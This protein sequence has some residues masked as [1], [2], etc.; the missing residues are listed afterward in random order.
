M[1]APAPLA[2]GGYGT[3]EVTAMLG[4]GAARLRALVRSGVVGT[5]RGALGEPRFGF[6]DLVLL[7][8]AQGL[9]AA[10]IPIRRVER[11]LAR[12]AAQLPEPALLS[13]LRITAERGEIV[14]RDGERAWNP[15]SGQVVLDFEVAEVAELAAVAAGAAVVTAARPVS[16]AALSFAAAVERRR[17]AAAAEAT[18]TA[19]APGSGATDTDVDTD[20]DT[21]TERDIDADGWYAVGCELEAH[22]P[23]AAVDAYARALAL[24]PAHADTHL[25]LGRLWHQTGNAVRAEHHYRLALAARP[26]D[27][28]AAF[29]LGV[30]LDDQGRDTDAAAAYEAAIAVDAAHAD[31]HYNL[32]LARERLGDRQAALRHL[33]DYRRLLRG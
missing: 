28:T 17:A 15:D 18:P 29:D 16:G 31:A 19:E 14:V 24:A 32:A 25:N 10:R 22:D 6:R 2:T 20:T 4:I 13:R 23:V 1:T 21:D 26:G 9:F 3:R 12:L 8:A 5:E 11:A 7:L 30:A 27:A 33:K